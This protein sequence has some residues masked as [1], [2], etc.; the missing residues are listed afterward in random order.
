MIRFISSLFILLITFSCAKK[1]TEG[2]RVKVKRVKTIEL[3]DSLDTLS[4]RTPDFFYSKIAT[5]YEDTN[6][7]VSF[8]TSLR[9][10]KDSALNA[11]ITYAAIPIVNALVTTDSLLVANKREKCVVRSDMAFLRENFGVDFSYKNI[12]E[13][14]LGLPLD[15][16]TTQKY[17]QIHEPYRY[18]LSS[19]RKRRIKV[20]ERRENKDKEKERFWEKPKEKEED[21]IRIKYFLSGYTM[22]LE[23]MEIYSAKDTTSVLVSYEKRQVVAGFSVPEKV[24]LKIFTPKNNITIEMSYDKVEVNE[25]QPLYFI[26]P[27]GYEDCE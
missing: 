16:D 1:L 24:V 6:R 26:I 8:K 10:A 18:V 22:E 5:K 21:D 9:M 27:E 25:P 13:L 11:I 14:L 15:Y 20:L 12:Q 17:F 7:N 4:R 3:T 19:D 23:G 2:E